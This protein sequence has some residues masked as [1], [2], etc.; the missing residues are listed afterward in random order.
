MIGRNYS[1][2]NASDSYDAVVRILAAV[3]RPG[4]R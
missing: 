4:V 3:S 2:L 1:H